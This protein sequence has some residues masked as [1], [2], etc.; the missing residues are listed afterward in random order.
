MTD[1]IFAKEA[2][3][4]ALKGLTKDYKVF[5]PAGDGD[6]HTFR[7]LE[8]GTKP[9]FGYRNTRL[10]P[11]SLVYPQ[12]ER[13]FDYS[14]DENEPDAHIL[15]EEQKDYGPQ[16]LVGIRPCDAHA[17]QIVK[18]NF[19]NR[20]TVIPSGSNVSSPPRSWDWGAMSRAPPASAP[21]WVEALL[22][23]RGWMPSCTTWVMPTLPG[24]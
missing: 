2:W 16:A 10:S 1:K 23:K 12:S 18:L 6:F 3:I 4:E 5:V 8:N 22:T 7:P 20:N 15:K 11:K 24:A 14:L 13:M 21:P 9:D 17:F 19:D